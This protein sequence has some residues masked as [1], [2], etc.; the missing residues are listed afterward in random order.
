MLRALDHFRDMRLTVAA[1]SAIACATQGA[2]AELTQYTDQANW[3]LAA[4]L[5]NSIEA[6]DLPVV[7]PEDHFI[8]SGVTLGAVFSSIGPSWIEPL[9]GLPV[10]SRVFSG[11]GLAPMNFRFTAPVTAFSMEWA[12]REAVNYHL[13]KGDDLIGYGQWLPQ[14][15]SLENPPFYGF[16][17]TVEFDR[18]SLQT[19][20]SPS[21]GQ[22]GRAVHFTQVVPAPAACLVLFC[23]FPRAVR[24]RRS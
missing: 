17:S 15:L 2:N 6:I 21:G 22:Y 24:R 5:V 9:W 4:G 14:E 10:G 19:Y 3:R 13:F 20:W 16:T 11:G 1:L 18:I 23:A 12:W 7:L 8:E